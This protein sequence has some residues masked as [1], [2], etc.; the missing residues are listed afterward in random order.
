M[1]RPSLTAAV[2]TL[3]LLWVVA[4]A[5]AQDAQPLRIGADVNGALTVG[6]A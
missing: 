2:S 4:P 6:D 5:V 3:A 1:N